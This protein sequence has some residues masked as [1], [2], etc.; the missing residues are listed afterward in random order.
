MAGGAAS[1]FILPNQQVLGALGPRAGAKLYFYATGTSTPQNTYS[2]STLSTPNTNPVIADSLGQFGNVFLLSSPSY[3]VALTDSLDASLW[4]MDPVGPTLALT[5]AVPVGGLMQYAG[6]SV[7]AGWLLCYGQQV[8]RTTYAL[9]F[10]AISTTWGIGDGTTTF[11]VPDFR[12][13]IALGKD[14][15]GGVAADRVTVAESGVASQTLGG[16]GGNQS[17]MAH[18]HNIDDPGHEHE[19]TDPGHFHSGPDSDAFLCYL[20][21]GGNS[22][23]T[24]GSAVLGVDHTATTTTG[25][26][27]AEATTGITTTAVA[28]TGNAQ[29]MPPVGV[30]N[31][32]IYAGA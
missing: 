10:A 25:L 14:N 32:M 15:M 6:A 19:V 22:N 30:V 11:N 18:F 5:A 1:R 13:R 29:N 8:S 7:P 2:D 26:T 16:T 20:G 12:G 4:T 21:T 23:I 17:I 31:T 28:G 24:G 9:L 3:R 27:V